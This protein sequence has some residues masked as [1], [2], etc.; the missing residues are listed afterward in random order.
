MWP[1][2]LFYLRLQCFHMS[3]ESLN[4]SDWTI[5]R[6]QPSAIALT[7]VEA[8]LR[9]SFIG[10]MLQFLSAISHFVMIAPGIHGD[11][12]RRDRLI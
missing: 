7:E 1:L 10:L 3:E 12:S 11:T 2:L 6:A 4:L 8:R 5:I 9:Q